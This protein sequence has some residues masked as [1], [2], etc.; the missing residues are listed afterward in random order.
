METIGPY[1]LGH[2]LGQGASAE[3]RL[4]THRYTGEEVAIKVIRKHEGTITTSTSLA[5]VN[6]PLRKSVS[7]TTSQGNQRLPPAIEREV[8]I[9]KLLDH[10]NLLRLV[11][12]WENKDTM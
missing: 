11:D 12:L 2:V 7:P 9:L 3:V 6:L 10:P 5:E 4:G 8:G 1:E